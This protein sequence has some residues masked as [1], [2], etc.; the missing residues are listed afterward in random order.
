MKWNRNEIEGRKRKNNKCDWKLTITVSYGQEKNNGNEK[1]KDTYGL[2][3]EERSEQK[4]DM[5]RTAT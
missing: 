2:E 3:W 1:M 4:C 5:K